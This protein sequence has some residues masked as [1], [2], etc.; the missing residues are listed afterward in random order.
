MRP[1]RAG[2]C[3]NRQRFNSIYIAGGLGP[4]GFVQWRCWPW[5][6]RLRVCASA[7]LRVCA[8]ARLR[9]CTSARLR[10]CA[11]KI[12][13]RCVRVL[14]TSRGAARPSPRFLWHSAGVLELTR[15]ESLG[16]GERLLGTMHADRSMKL[17]IPVCQALSSAALSVAT[18]LLPHLLP[19]PCCH[20]PV[21]TSL[22][23]RRSTPPAS[24]FTTAPIF[25]SEPPH[26]RA[27]Q[28]VLQRPFRLSLSRLG[29]NRL[30]LGRLGL[31]RLGLSGFGLGPRTV[32]VDPLSNRVVLRCRRW[33]RGG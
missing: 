21:A 23:V 2:S 16:H 13:S 26:L 14:G 18:S 31:G 19:H 15:R 30:G 25:L 5:A 10:V 11:R 1:G 3:L 7:R 12:W 4:S 32:G 28:D 24:V 27:H 8:S 9:V 6:Q 29:L 22:L 20:I 33:G 17:S